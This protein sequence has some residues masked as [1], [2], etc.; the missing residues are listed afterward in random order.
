MTP[1]NRVSAL[2]ARCL[3]RLGLVLFLAVATV[4]PSA[5]QGVSDEE[6]A[7][8][9]VALTEGNFNAK[10]EAVTALAALGDARA[11]D[12]LEAM[13]ER[14]LYVRESDGAVLIGLAERGGDINVRDPVTGEELGPVSEDDLEAV[15]IN[16]RLRIALRAAI[17]M[18]AIS[19][20][21]PAVRIAAAQELSS[22][23][24][25][26][27]Q[28]LLAA[29]LEREEDPA[30]R[31][32]LELALAE[33]QLSADDPALRIEAVQHIGETTSPSA[34]ALLS[35]LL[36]QNSDGTYQEPDEGVR[37]AAQEALESV[38]S[39]LELVDIGLNIFQGVSLGSV[40]LLAAIGLA[41][42]FGVMGVINMA[43][44]EM[45]MLG[46]YTTFVVQEA[47]RAYLPAG[48]FDA[49]VVLAV[50]AAFLVAGGV[51]VL[52]ERLVIRFLYG[53]TLETLL[54]TWG[55]S[56]A[57][58]QTVRLVFGAPN[59]EVSNPGWMTGGVEMFGGAAI[60][61]YNRI[62]IIVFSL[63]VL[64][65]MALVI[66]YTHYGLE[67]RA[68]SQNRRMASAMGIR[69]GWVDA[70]TFGLGSG[71][72]GVG[73]V[74]LSQIG[75]VSPNLGQSYI[76]DSFM[77]VVFGGVGSLWGVLAGAMSM[78]IVTKFLE[79]YAGAVL[80]KILVLIALILF[81]QRYPRGLFALKGRAAE[82]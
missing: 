66:R 24:S 68:V 65:L 39:R 25:E 67:M 44:G 37:A 76:V 56:L 81:I 58:Q 4:G 17:G 3:V 30:V 27:N 60:L 31:T 34:R 14:G 62:V 72:A 40:L 52:M 53:R 82:G 74:A 6:F 43:H 29:A 79:P 8:A 57:L 9:V 36:R 26:E 46:A 33:I 49:Y 23:D 64:A 54:A 75:N 1:V 73:G 69:S 78:G 18:M 47:F 32:V 45:L 41:I 20:P 22:D 77:V 19:D 51:G 70:L 2:A 80:G 10:A 12:V 5:A 63:C 16:N 59:R 13:L 28:A 71:I 7:A 42:T 38:E 21:D 50:P 55:I 35:R 11:R 61:T 15:R 48:W